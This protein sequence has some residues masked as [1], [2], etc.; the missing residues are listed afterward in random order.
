MK[1]DATTTSPAATAAHGD[2]MQLTD[3]EIDSVGGGFWPIVA[4]I[5]LGAAMVAAHGAVFQK[6]GRLGYFII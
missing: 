2:F 4:M 6:S 3:D 5:V 1:T